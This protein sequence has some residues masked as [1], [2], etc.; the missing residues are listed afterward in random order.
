MEACISRAAKRPRVE[1]V[2]LSQILQKAESIDARKFRIDFASHAWE[3]KQIQIVFVEPDGYLF[4]YDCNLSLFNVENDVDTTP[5]S[6]ESILAD[7]QESDPDSKMFLAM[8]RANVP[9][10]SYNWMLYYTALPTEQKQKSE[11]TIQRLNERCKHS[12]LVFGLPHQPYPQVDKQDFENQFTA[13]CASKG[14]CVL[15]D[16][17][18]YSQDTMN[19]SRNVPIGT[20]DA[21]AL[22]ELVNIYALAV[23]LQLAA[24]CPLDNLVHEMIY[25][26]VVHCKLY[27]DRSGE[28]VLYY[29]VEKQKKNNLI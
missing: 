18:T 22:K 4:G 13:H 7:M 27:K 14:C 17:T 6:Y 9:Q 5:R 16:L 26:E 23:F 19:V 24:P 2:A 15:W 1:P 3:K 20:K 21:D 28:L 10:T 25:P 12:L 29:E 8:L 11:E